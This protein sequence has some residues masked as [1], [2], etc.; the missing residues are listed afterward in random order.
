MQLKVPLGALLRIAAL[1]FVLSLIILKLLFPDPFRS[2][3]VIYPSSTHYADHLLS[4]G[5]RF[6]DEKESG[7]YIELLTSGNVLSEMVV[8]HKLIEHY[9]LTDDKKP[10]E[11]A[12]NILKQ[13]IEVERS[14]NRSLHITVS[15]KDG[16]MSAALS[17]RLVQA[18]DEHLSK[19]IKEMVSREYQ[20]VRNIY[21]EK[22]SEVN[23][24]RDSLTRMHLRGEPRVVDNSVI[25]SPN[26]ANLRQILETETRHMLEQK[27]QYELLNSVLLKNVPPAYKISEAVAPEKGSF[28]KKI[29]FSILLALAACAFYLIL[30]NRKEI[31][32]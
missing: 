6:G 27:V 31:G 21:K 23:R 8:K 15:D 12:V 17:K 1:T 25:E 10:L 2:T 20:V 9:Q 4:A 11:R 18:A 29:V 19:I 26:Y 5:L 3:T 30:I 28:V 16:P 14:P 24:L 22:I 32:L 13:N 7:E